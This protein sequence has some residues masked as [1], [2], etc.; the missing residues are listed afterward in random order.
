[1]EKKVK[2]A[3]RHRKILSFRYDGYPRVVEP[4]CLGY[5][6]RGNLSLRAY[7][8]EGSGKTRV[9]DWKLFE[10]SKIRDL[11][12]T[13]DRFNNPRS[14]YSPNDRDLSPIIEDLR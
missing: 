5:T 7:Q 9:P 8:T 13:G 1:M 2:K 12:V 14:G 11:E 10:T 4:H 3:I 6:D